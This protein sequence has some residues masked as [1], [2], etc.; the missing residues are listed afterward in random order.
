M[1]LKEWGFT[2]S[3]IA[4]ELIEMDQ[5]NLAYVKP[6]KDIPRQ[7]HQDDGVLEAVLIQSRYVC[8]NATAHFAFG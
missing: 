3:A 1:Q 8:T 7:S 4:K 6:D 2:L 5:K